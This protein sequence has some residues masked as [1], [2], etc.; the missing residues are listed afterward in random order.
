MVKLGH[1]MKLWLDCMRHQAMSRDKMIKLCNAAKD[2]W[3]SNHQ[4]MPFMNFTWSTRALKLRGSLAAKS[5]RTL[6][7][8]CMLFCCIPCMKAEYGTCKSV[9]WSG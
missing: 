7:L 8:T 9:T 4:L 6:R 3:A 5:A 1:C 2:V